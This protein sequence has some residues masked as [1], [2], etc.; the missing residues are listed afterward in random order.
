MVSEK[1]VKKGGRRR[2]C[3][4]EV[5]EEMNRERND[6][7]WIQKRDQRRNLREVD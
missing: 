7:L 2:V 6:H 4:R 3:E 5:E 1:R